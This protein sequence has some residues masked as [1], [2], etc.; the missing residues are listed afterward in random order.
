MKSFL[1]AMYVSCLMAMLQIFAAPPETIA[2]RLSSEPDHNVEQAVSG[3]KRDTP[4]ITVPLILSVT[5]PDVLQFKEE[6]VPVEGL[7]R[8]VPTAI[9]ISLPVSKFYDETRHEIWKSCSC[10]SAEFIRGDSQSGPATAIR[11]VA[12]PSQYLFREVLYIFDRDTARHDGS[13]EGP[14]YV[15]DLAKCSFTLQGKADCPNTQIGT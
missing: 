14:K 2:Q 12:I 15:K 11:V 9:D 1:T 13:G 3:L 8:G 5:L 6:V 4:A 7:I 10:F